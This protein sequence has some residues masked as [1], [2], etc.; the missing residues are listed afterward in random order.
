MDFDM[1]LES[2]YP[3][4]RF[5]EFIK[6]FHTDLV[7]Y[8]III[9]NVKLLKHMQDDLAMLYEDCPEYV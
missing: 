6:Q 7:P 2:V 1:L 3:H 5:S 4:K 8:L 9:R